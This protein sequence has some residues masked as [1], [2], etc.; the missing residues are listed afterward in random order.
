GGGGRGDEG[1][2][3]GGGEFEGEVVDQEVVAE[4]LLEAVEIDDV[5]AQPLRHRDDDLRGLGGLFRR[6][7]HQLL[8]ALIARLRFGLAGARAGGD[9]FALARERA[10]AR[11]LLA[12][13]LPR[14]LL[15]LPQPRRV[16]A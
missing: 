10:L 1:E 12:A 5:L 8:V 16:G 14:P 4:A 13:L 2:D 7:L 9:P 3:G 6:L 11:L 15:L